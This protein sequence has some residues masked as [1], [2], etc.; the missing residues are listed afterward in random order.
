[1]GLRDLSGLQVSGAALAWLVLVLVIGL[2]RVLR[3]LSGRSSDGHGGLAGFS[4]GPGAMLLVILVAILP[5]IVL[6][7]LWF[8]QR[9]R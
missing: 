2:P 7:G 3:F 1:M 9:G 4:F 5:P 6:I 8:A